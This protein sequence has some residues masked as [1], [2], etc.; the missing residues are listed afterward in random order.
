MSITTQSK[1]NI[2]VRDKMNETISPET[3]DSID[4]SDQA[5]QQ[6]S[7]EAGYQMR[8]QLSEK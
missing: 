1:T 2:L 5:D 4:E 7:P 3:L 6:S 8:P